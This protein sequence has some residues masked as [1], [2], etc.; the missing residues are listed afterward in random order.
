VKTIWKFELSVMNVQEV[1]MPCEA[2]ILT[3]QT[4][5]KLDEINRPYKTINIWA[6][7]QT[8]NKIVDRK[9]IMYGTG[10]ELPENPG[11]YI[12]TVQLNDGQLVLHV[13]EK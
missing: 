1:K 11:D 7:C 5:T 9:I 13:Y 10:R 6:V 2:K 8:E 4:Q 12:G 3:V